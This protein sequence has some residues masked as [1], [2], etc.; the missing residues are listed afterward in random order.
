MPIYAGTKL[1]V[2]TLPPDTASYPNPTSLIQKRERET[3]L[4][5]RNSREKG[6]KQGKRKEERVQEITSK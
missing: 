1:V 5:N 6:R 4:R 3:V 2:S